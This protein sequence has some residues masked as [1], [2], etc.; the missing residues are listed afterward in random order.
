MQISDFRENYAFLRT[1]QNPQ[2]RPSRDRPRAGS[3]LLTG[4]EVASTAGKPRHQLPKSR[5]AAAAEDG[6]PLCEK[7]WVALGPATFEFGVDLHHMFHSYFGQTQ[8]TST[9]A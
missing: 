7:S 8:L 3:K 6:T 4:A 2:A 9:H 1:S 5:V